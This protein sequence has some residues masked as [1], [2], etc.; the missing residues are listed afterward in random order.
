VN[1]AHCKYFTTNVLDINDIIEC[2]MPK[3]ESFVIY[4]CVEGEAEIL[5]NDKDKEL[6][7][8]GETIL[9]PAELAY[10]H[11]KPSPKAKL[12]EIYVAYNEEN[13]D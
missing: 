6:I 1:I 13:A 4:M 10:Y 12:L 7:R 5:Y 8:K 3:F 9:M 11:I 2:D